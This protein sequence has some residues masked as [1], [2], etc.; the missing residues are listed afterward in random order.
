MLPVLLSSP[1]LL[2][3]CRRPD[4]QQRLLRLRRLPSRRHCRRPTRPRGR[5]VPRAP[6]AAPAVRRRRPSAHLRAATPAVAVA[7]GAGPA[8]AAGLLADEPAMQ[9]MSTQ[10]HTGRAICMTRA[11][12]YTRCWLVHRHFLDNIMD[13]LCIALVCGAS[14]VPLCCSSKVRQC[15]LRYEAGIVGV[16]PRNLFILPLFGALPLGAGPGTAICHRRCALCRSMVMHKTQ[17]RAA[18]ASNPTDVKCVHERRETR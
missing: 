2:L 10:S 8:V 3:S 7:V 17:H 18:L 13:H 14:G 16:Q 4:L 11:S 5:A 6:A 9:Q 12:Q 15:H 1:A